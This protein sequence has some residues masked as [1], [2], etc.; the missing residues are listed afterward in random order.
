MDPLLERINDSVNV[1]ESTEGREK[2]ST[3]ARSEKE[4]PAIC[5]QSTWNNKREGEGTNIGRGDESIEL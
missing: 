2:R 1:I 5:D 3:F 4:S